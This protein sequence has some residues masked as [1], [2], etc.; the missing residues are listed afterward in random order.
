[1]R[2]FS[3]LVI[4]FL[5]VA[6]LYAE[7]SKIDP[8]AT[9]Y[10]L[11]E[12][13]WV[14][15]FDFTGVY[16]NLEEIEIDAKKKYRVEMLLTGEYPV[17]EQ[18][19]YHGGYGILKGKLTGHFPQVEEVVIDCNNAQINL[20][21]RGEWEKDCHITIRG[22]TGDIALKLPKN[23]GVVAHTKLKGGK[24]IS[25]HLVKQGRGWRNKTFVNE[26]VGHEDT[27]TLTLD[28]ESTKGSIL[29]N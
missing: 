3:F 2:R 12:K 29:L 14:D 5:T 9:A 6:S 26:L 19:E 8:D 23:I 10:K 13:K 21:L 22:T 25:S 20:D 7:V 15:T 24:V 17:L 1:M 16:P 4:C 28:V 27:I 11:K 18:I